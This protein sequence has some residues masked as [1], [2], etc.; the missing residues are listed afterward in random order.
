MFYPNIVHH[1]T[2]SKKKWRVFSFWVYTLYRVKFIAN[3]P[4]D[5]GQKPNLATYMVMRFSCLIVYLN[6]LY[7]WTRLR[8]LLWRLQICQICKTTKVWNNSIQ[9]VETEISARKN[10]GSIT[11]NLNWIKKKVMTQNV[12]YLKECK[13][14]LRTQ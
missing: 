8:V 10:K 3:S 2:F 11:I 5:L 13:L 1:L 4:M 6:L 14:K 7:N 12:N 9:S